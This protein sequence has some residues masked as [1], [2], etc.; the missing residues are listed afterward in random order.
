M[1]GHHSFVGMDMLTTGRHSIGASAIGRRTAFGIGAPARS[2]DSGRGDHVDRMA[3]R[4]GAI[5][6][7]PT[8]SSGS[9]RF[10]HVDRLMSDRSGGSR[11]D[12]VDRL[13]SD[14]SGRASATSGPQRAGVVVRLVASICAFWQ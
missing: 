7:L 9:S 13:M 12:H 5:D 10:D 8:R 3:E 6:E 11:F 2:S 14:R 1:S 4:D